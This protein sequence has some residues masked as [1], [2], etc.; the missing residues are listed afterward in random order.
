MFLQRALLRALC[1]HCTGTVR[2][3]YFGSI[4]GSGASAGPRQCRPLAETGQVCRRAPAR[5]CTGT[6]LCQHFQGRRKHW[7]AAVQSAPRW[8]QLRGRIP[9][10]AAGPRARAKRS[11]SL[12]G[13]CIRDRALRR[14]LPLLPQHHVSKD[15]RRKDCAVP[16][17]SRLT[18]LPPPANVA[19]ERERE[20]ESK[21]ER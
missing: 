5:H 9:S 13:N 17:V 14:N 2:A 10:R 21:S 6:A 19:H 15:N 11:A 8:R 1:G 20:S 3:L 16:T 4:C 18:N 7:A 12:R